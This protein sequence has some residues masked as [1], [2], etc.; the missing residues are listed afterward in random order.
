MD[1]WIN[2]AHDDLLRLFKQVDGLVIND[3]EAE[4]LTEISNSISAARRIIETSGGGPTF[5]IVKKGEHG[6]ILVHE[7]GVATIA[8][9]RRPAQRV[10][11]DHGMTLRDASAYNVQFHHGRPLLIDTLSFEPHQDGTP[12]AAYKQIC[13]HLLLPLKLMS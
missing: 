11:L 5:V 4:Q 8:I 1:L 12:W 10:A 6:A 2:I 7:D 13:E 9:G 3:S